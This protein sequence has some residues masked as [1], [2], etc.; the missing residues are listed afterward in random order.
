[1]PEI[2]SSRNRRFAGKTCL[3]TGGSRG[4]GRAAARA[5]VREGARVAIVGRDPAQLA[6][7]AAEIGGDVLTISADLA[8]MAGIAAVAAALSKWTDRLDVAYVNAG[9]SGMKPLM[10]MDEAT[11]DRVFNTNLKSAFFLVQAVKPQLARGGAIVFCGSAASRKAN[12][13]LA[14]YATS[15]AALNHLTRVLAAELVADEVRVNIVIPGGMNTDIAFHTEGMDP[16]VGLAL[17]ERIRLETPMRREG[18][19]EEVADAILFLASREASYITGA[20]LVVDG[21]VTSFTRL[22]NN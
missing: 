17:R 21:G 16:K 5:F 12:V 3:V 8:T 14:A 2:E 9:Y 18:E 4:L 13:G 6:T 19:P 20:S 11:W 15:K 10:A 1:M 22:A 7:A